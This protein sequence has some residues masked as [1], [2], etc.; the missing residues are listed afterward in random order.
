M[1]IVSFLS[2]A[3]EIVA[4]LGLADRLVGI[5]H[6]CDFP[7]HVL[8]LPVVSRSRFDPQGLT[9]GEVDA[10]V[11]RSMEEFG[12]VYTVDE[13]LLRELHPDLILTQAVCEVCA[14]PTGAVERA[15]EGL[16][17]P[18]ETLSLDAHTLEGMLG[19][20]SRVAD[21]AGV[22]ER[23]EAVV[24]RLRGRLNAVAERV[25]GR[26][27]PRTLALEW[28]DPPFAPGH[29]L[30]E[31][32]V[33]AGGANLLGSAGAPSRE[34]EWAELHGLDPEVLCL[35]PC[36]WGI[37]AARA[38]ADRHRERVRSVAPGARAWVGAGSF[39]SRSGPR[40]VDGTEA[41]A[42]ALHPE[43]FE[44]GPPAGVLEPWS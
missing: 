40:L 29:W 25:G 17:D 27:R 32:V 31:M 12:S 22:P 35:L 21:A 23:G 38:D 26:R 42:A 33:A 34:A 7:A 13:G 43:V 18:V 6:E 5:S 15:A 44:Q 11:R 41:L 8:D 3:T 37:E 24:A 1:R 10:A 9:S 28:L 2:S 19:T 20:I 39:F 16:P 14:V 4:A 30:P 36:G